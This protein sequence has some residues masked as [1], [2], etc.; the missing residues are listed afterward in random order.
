MF[1]CDKCDKAISCIIVMIFFNI[2]TSFGVK[3]SLK[4]LRLIEYFFKQ[5]LLSSL[6]C[7]PIIFIMA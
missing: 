5:A 6:L 1:V 3:F 4:W 7:H 2:T